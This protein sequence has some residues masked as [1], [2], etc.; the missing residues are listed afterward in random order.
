VLL[1]VRT[2]PI[3]PLPDAVASHAVKALFTAVCVWHAAVDVGVGQVIAG[4]A[5]IVTVKQLLFAVQA[6]PLNVLVV[7]LR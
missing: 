4:V 7:T 3:P 2:P 1:L 5:A 6:N